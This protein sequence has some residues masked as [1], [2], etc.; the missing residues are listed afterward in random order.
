MNRRV[1]A[2]MVGS[3]LVASLMVA[4]VSDKSIAQIGG[5][6]RV[7]QAILGLTEIAKGQTQALVNTTENRG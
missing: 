6:S 2:V 3:A 7:L 5:E 1:L 4:S